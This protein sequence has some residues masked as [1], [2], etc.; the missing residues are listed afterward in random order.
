MHAQIC[1]RQIDT[2]TFCIFSDIAE[3]ICYLKSLPQR[4]RVGVCLPERDSKDPHAEK[5]DGRRHLV[6]IELEVLDGF[7]AIDG[8]IRHDTIDQIIK[9]LP[10]QRECGDRP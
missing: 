8:E 5:T 6:A 7:L 9:R 10:G 4:D 2:P 3:N 1:E